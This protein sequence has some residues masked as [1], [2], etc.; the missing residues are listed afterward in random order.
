MKIFIDLEKEIIIKTDDE[1]RTLYRADENAD[2]IKV[3]FKESPT[4]W[5]LSLGATLA[6]GRNIDARYHDGV[7]YN[8]TIDGV[9]YYYFT[10]TLSRQNGFLLVNG[11][12]K[13]TLYHNTTDTNGKVVRQKA[14]GT[15]VINV[16]NTT[17]TENNILVTGD[18]A[19]EVVT[20]VKLLLE[21]LQAIINTLN[22]IVICNNCL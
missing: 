15:F 16:A 9:D 3:Y 1:D 6:N 8:E 21:Q 22:V 17:E 2:A 10:F 20:N 11:S 7:V 18:D 5:Y 12:T 13:F 14:V 19:G 4:N